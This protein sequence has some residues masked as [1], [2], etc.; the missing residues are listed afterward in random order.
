[1]L[2]GPLT[3]TKISLFLVTLDQNFSIDSGQESCERETNDTSKFL[4]S[5][6]LRKVTSK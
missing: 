2:Q 4:H 6:E 3:D 5:K 1:M